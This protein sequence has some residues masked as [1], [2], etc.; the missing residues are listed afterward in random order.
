[1]IIQEILGKIKYDDLFYA[2]GPRKIKQ[3]EKL[4]SDKKHK[5]SIDRDFIGQAVLSYY[6][7]NLFFESRI[8]HLIFNTIDP[9]ILKNLTHKYSSKV[10]DKNYDNALAL[11][12]LPWKAGS[13][14]VSEISDV[15]GISSDYL[16]TKIELNLVIENI[17]PTRPLFPLH[18]YQSDIK[19]L[20]INELQEGNPRFLIQMPTGSGKT[21]TA[22]QSIIEYD[23]TANL[24]NRERIVLWLAHTQ[25]LCEQAI[26]TMEDLWLNLSTYQLKI[27]RCWG[28]YHPSAT[29]IT[30]GFV[31]GTFQKF[32]GL[33]KS[34]SFLLNSIK[35]KLSIIV[36][37]EA[38]KSTSYS[39]SKVINYLAA[40]KNVTLIGLTA[41][42]GRAYL[43]TIENSE[44]AKFYDKKL[45]APKFKKNPIIELREKGILAKL[46][47]RLIDTKVD[48]DV[49]M[50]D[51]MSLTMDISSVTIQKLATNNNRNKL[52]LSIIEDEV[53]KGNPCLIFSCSVEHSKLLSAALNFTGMKSFYVDGEM[54]KV[55]RK[56]VIDDFKNGKY[57]ILFNYGVLSTGF[58]APRIRTLILARPTSSVVLYSQMI[59]RGLRGPKMGGAEVCNLIDLKDNFKN[60]GG[61]EEVYSYFEDYWK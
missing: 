56:Q 42:P 43:N 50:G 35:R 1:L 51:E 54:R 44:L 16:P 14:F 46:N 3:F 2:L 4:I 29:D 20:I 9:T 36:V 24:F 33:L 23:K 60:F 37:D 53:K 39:Y 59:G 30:G 10:Y 21:R 40:Q 18:D 47:R 27:V 32:Y 5:R 15:L 25:E 34:E 45:I 48:I 12:I 55:I 7:Y 57:D 13:E 49:E 8:R 41:T 26:D 22:L 6:G 58:D 38:H 11:S 52:I 28:N 17:E 31:I 61:V 19:K